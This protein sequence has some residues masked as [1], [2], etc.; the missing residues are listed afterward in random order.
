MRQPYLRIRKASARVPNKKTKAISINLARARL[1]KQIPS[2][3][4]LPI[5]PILFQPLKVRVVAEAETESDPYLEAECM[6]HVDQSGHGP[7]L[8][9]M[10]EGKTKT[11]VTNAYVI[12][13]AAAAIV[14]RAATMDGR[15]SL[16]FRC[17]Q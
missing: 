11:T 7:A 5:G 13:C 4:T 16:F 15:A 6:K 10:G 2:I 3:E 8:P 9:D 1:A 17:L 12:L 14:S